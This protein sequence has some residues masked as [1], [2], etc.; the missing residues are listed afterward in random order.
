MDPEPQKGPKDR[1]ADFTRDS[2]ILALSLMALVIGSVSALAA[3]ALVWL[4]AATTNPC[5]FGHARRLSSRPQTIGRAFGRLLCPSG[6][7]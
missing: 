1:L 6:A 3:Y 2:R 5:Y 7:V 4:I